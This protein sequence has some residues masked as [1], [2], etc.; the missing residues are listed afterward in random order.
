[1]SGTIAVPSAVRVP[2]AVLESAELTS[3]EK[4][5]WVAL[6]ARVGM[7]GNQ[8]FAR[9]RLARSL[10]MC[11]QTV[12]G[13]MRQ[14][15]ALGW[16]AAGK[17]CEPARLA[18]HAAVHALTIPVPLRLLL[19]AS[20]PVRA[21]VVR[22]QLG[23]VRARDGELPNRYAS[24]A[25]A[26]GSGVKAVRRAVR[27]LVTSHWLALEQTNRV[28]P[29]SL[30]AR[31]PVRESF[32][33]LKARI[34]MD[35]AVAEFTGEAF[36]NAAVLVLVGSEHGETH[37][38]PDWLRNPETDA[39]M[40]FDRYH[41]PERVALEFNGPQHDHA[42][43]LYD[44]EAVTRQRALDVIKQEVSDA[45]G[46]HLIIVRPQDLS[47]DTLRRLVQG[48]L[49]LRDLVGGE[50]VVRFVEKLLSDYRRACSGGFATS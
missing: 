13:A 49:P 16:Y 6:A 27:Q 33:L 23:A 7:L 37:A 39:K 9:T 22:M 29:V 26:I 42:T 17:P 38:A 41:G 8:R 14:L 48:W 18:K 40:H 12:A 3:S 4:L 34:V 44:E 50:S 35:I 25:Q 21:R 15:A 36:M 46:V 2:L 20:I 31:N 19:D 28:A 30:T 24:V 11:R 47:L 43:D 1:V 32:D 45:N 10:G 5:I